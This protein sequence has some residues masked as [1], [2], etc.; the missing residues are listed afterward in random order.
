MTRALPVALVLAVL[1]VSCAPKK[2]GIV[3]DTERVPASTLI[4]LVEANDRG[5]G[6]IVG[7]G[8][9]TF[10]SPQLAGSASFDLSMKRPDSLL[11]SFEGPFGIDLGTLFLSRGRY[12]MYNSRENSVVT[13][14]P[15]T[16]AIRSV[17]PF[18]LSYDEILGAFSGFVAFPGEPRTLRQYT[19][20]DDQFSISFLRGDSVWN[21]WIDPVHVRVS[22]CEI[23]DSQQR[24][25]LEARF[26][27]FVEQQKASI[28]K[29]IRISFPLED[30]Y[31]ALS[32]SKIAV[33]EPNPSFEFS[34][35][36]NAHTL[37]R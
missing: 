26:S 11:A 20:M 27:N 1:L 6:S 29:R 13:G 35:P 25:V 2:A 10:E 9:V 36:P 22:R 28:P 3:L 34:I 24:T 31:L 18:D 14:V 5:I 33:N 37:V 12:V 4:G 30:R 8:I 23:L 17:I 21:Y 32:Y 7:R 19:I 15:S 16:K